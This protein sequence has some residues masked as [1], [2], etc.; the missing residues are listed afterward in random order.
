MLRLFRTLKPQCSSEENR[1]ALELAWVVEILQ[2]AAIIADDMMDGSLVRRGRPCW[3]RQ[4]QIGM[5][6][7]NDVLLLTG[8]TLQVVDEILSE[9]DKYAPITRLLH[10]T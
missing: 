4:P 6:A 2:A 7:V 3:Y 5:S 8:V 1:Q 10:K 9:S